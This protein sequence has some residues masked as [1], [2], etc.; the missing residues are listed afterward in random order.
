MS[1]EKALETDKKWM[2][3]ALNSNTNHF[4]ITYGVSRKKAEEY[5]QIA[6]QHYSNTTK[7]GHVNNNLEVIFQS[8]DGNPYAKDVF[9]VA[10][11]L[12]E[13]R[14]GLAEPKDVMYSIEIYTTMYNVS[15]EQFMK[16]CMQVQSYAEYQVRKK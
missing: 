4:M 12:E 5:H 10:V 14:F 15:Q 1:L 16:D 11:H 2:E 3:D 8:F 13:C 9:A 6:I 7:R